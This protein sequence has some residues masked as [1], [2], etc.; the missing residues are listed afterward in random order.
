MYPSLLLGLVLGSFTGAATRAVLTRPTMY[1]PLPVLVSGSFPGAVMRGE[2]N[3]LKTCLPNGIANDRWFNW[4]R[5]GDGSFQSVVWKN[6]DYQK[7]PGFNNQTED[8]SSDGFW[9]GSSWLDKFGMYYV[10]AGLLS[11]S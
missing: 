9:R 8:S 11:A 5:Y 10:V 6:F 3:R 2:P 7:W 1:P 4:R